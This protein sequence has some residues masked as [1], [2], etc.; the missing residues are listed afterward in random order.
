MMV[1]ASALPN[2]SALSTHE[3]AATGNSIGDRAAL[4]VKIQYSEVKDE[5]KKT[6][7]LK[8]TQGQAEFKFDEHY[9]RTPLKAASFGNVLYG[10]NLTKT[11]KGRFSHLRT[12][13]DA[14][15]LLNFYKGKALENFEFM[16]S[17]NPRDIRVIVLKKL[18]RRM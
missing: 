5:G 16:E 14:V 1:A 18:P 17:L 6:F 12:I 3:V 7:Q 8:I 10:S 2:L 11:Y 4:N 15:T 13:D 9:F